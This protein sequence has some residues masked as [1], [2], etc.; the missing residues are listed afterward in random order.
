MIHAVD[1]RGDALGQFIKQLTFGMVAPNLMDLTDIL[2][3]HGHFDVLF[4]LSGDLVRHHID[5]EHQIVLM[6]VVES[7]IDVDDSL[8]LDDVAWGC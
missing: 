1:I 8:D 6:F 3:F 2:G 7:S 4:L 5:V